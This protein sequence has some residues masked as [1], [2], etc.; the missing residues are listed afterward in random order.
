VPHIVTMVADI[1]MVVDIGMAVDIGTAAGA[2]AG[3]TIIGIVI[4]GMASI[5]PIVTGC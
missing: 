3:A 4:G 5:T 2:M 1:D